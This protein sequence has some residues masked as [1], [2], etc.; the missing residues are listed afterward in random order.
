MKSIACAVAVV[1]FSSCFATKRLTDP[2]H[3]SSRR[4]YWWNLARN[5][6]FDNL[7]SA[8][9]SIA[10]LAVLGGV[11]AHAGGASI[12]RGALRVTFWGALAM[13]LTAGELARWNTV[14][15]A[16]AM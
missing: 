8:A 14:L 16:G 13:A 12:A 15:L 7:A 10:L 5:H 3:H 9:A 1:V 4:I 2:V 6:P 11:G